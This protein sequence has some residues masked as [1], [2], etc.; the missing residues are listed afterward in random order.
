MPELAV[1]AAIVLLALLWWVTRQLVA[2]QA[3]R[4]LAAARWEPAHHALPDGGVEVVLERPG[5]SDIPLARLDPRDP[6]FEDRLHEAMAQARVRAAALNSERA[7][8][9]R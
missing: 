4:R 7:I 1:A 3:D 6:A 8:A 9:R 2:W 5:E